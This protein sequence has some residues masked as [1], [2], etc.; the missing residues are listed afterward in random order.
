MVYSLTFFQTLKLTSFDVMQ[1][2]LQVNA[3]ICKIHAV[4][5]VISTGSTVL[6]KF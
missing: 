3:N 1:Y 4:S 5:C 2:K 6:N